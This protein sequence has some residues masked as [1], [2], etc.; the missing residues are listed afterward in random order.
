MDS[1]WKRKKERRA[2]APSQLRCSLAGPQGWRDKVGVRAFSKT[3]GCQDCGGAI[4]ALASN[5][6][7]YNRQRPLSRWLPRQSQSMGT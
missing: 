1:A 4:A 7:D 5:T 2:R 3:P 6:S